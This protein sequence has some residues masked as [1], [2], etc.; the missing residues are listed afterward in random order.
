[1]C[2]D[3]GRYKKAGRASSNWWAEIGFTY[4]PESEGRLPMPPHPP[5][6]RHWHSFTHNFQTSFHFL[7]LL[8]RVSGFKAVY[9]KYLPPELSMIENSGTYHLPGFFINRKFSIQTIS[10]LKKS[11][12]LPDSPSLT[13]HTVHV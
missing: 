11:G 3:V 6:P 2:R 10:T 8:L 9:L 5:A 12:G 4:L 13:A 7:E 1:M